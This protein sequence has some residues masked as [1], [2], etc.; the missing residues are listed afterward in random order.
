MKKT[1]LSILL[2]LLLSKFC[3]GQSIQ[4]QHSQLMAERMTAV[5]KLDSMQKRDIYDINMSLSMQKSEARKW[6]SDLDSLTAVIQAIEN[7]RDSLYTGVLDTGEY[8]LYKQHKKD[9]IKK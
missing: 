3:S 8:Q 6:Y 1:I 4:Q 5:C 7:T 2:V 9:I